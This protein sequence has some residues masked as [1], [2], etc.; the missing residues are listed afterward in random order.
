LGHRH[1]VS[2]TEI[3]GKQVEHTLDCRPSKT[4]TELISHDP[5]RR[6]RGHLACKI[7]RIGLFGWVVREREEEF[8]TPEGKCKC[9]KLCQTA[10]RGALTED[11]KTKK[12]G[13]GRFRR[14]AQIGEGYKRAVLI[15]DQRIEKFGAPGK[16]SV[17]QCAVGSG[18][19]KGKG[20]TENS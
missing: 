3:S 18:E 9:G 12:W 6:C 5:V 19:M 11:R 8:K 10:R 20:C 7:G 14:L 13:E 16:G 1:I 4:L 17:N 2:R 15:W